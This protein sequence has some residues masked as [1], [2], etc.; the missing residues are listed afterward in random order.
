MSKKPLGQILFEAEEMNADLPKWV[1]TY[2][3]VPHR[4]LMNHHVSSVQFVGHEPHTHVPDVVC[5][6]VAVGVTGLTVRPAASNG[7]RS[8]EDVVK[9][10]V[11]EMQAA[12]E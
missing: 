6:T 10:L 5:V 11:S 1:P 3:R 9:I 4:C 12:G 8:E 7:L 2:N